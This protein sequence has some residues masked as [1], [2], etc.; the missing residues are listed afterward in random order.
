MAAAQT[1][2]TVEPA[3]APSVS[4]SGAAVSIWV[5]A[6]WLLPLSLLLAVMA[7][8][9][10]PIALVVPWV[11]SLDLHFAFTIDGLNRLFLFLITGVGAVIFFYTPAYLHGHPRLGM[12]MGLLCVFL[13]SMVGAV[14]AD[15]LLLLFL[16]WELTSVLSFLL[17]GFEH[18]KKVVRDSAQH[19]LL[20]TAGGGLALFGGFLL[21]LQAAPGLRLSDLPHL[22][23]VL[24]EDYRFNAGVV[25]VLIGAMTKS[26]QFP[27]HFWLPGAMAAPTPISAYLHSATMVKLGVYLM[28]RFDEAMGAVDWW[29]T[30]LTVIGTVTALWGAIHS[31]RERDMKAILAWSTVSALGTLTLLVGLPNELSALAFVAF[32]VAHASYKATLF[33]VV[34]NV[35]HVAGTR[36]IDRLR[37]MGRAM[38]MT[39]AAAIL[40]GLSMAGLP[41]SIGFIAKDTIK[42]S[43]ELAESAWPIVGAGV[44]VSAIGVAVAAVATVRIFLGPSNDSLCDSAH[45]EGVR[46]RLSPLVLAVLGIVLGLAPGLMQPILLDAAR[47]IAPTLQA[48][49][50]AVDNTWPTRLG[51]LAVVMMLG[52]IIYANWDRLHRCLEELKALER[53]GPASAYESA[54]GLLKGI[55]GATT[56]TLQSGRSSRYLIAT[57]VAI[58]VLL[59]P[60]LVQLAPRF[61]ELR[62]KGDIGLLLG[63]FTAI[64]GA[65]ISASGRDTLQ[66]LLGAG[67]V[68]YGSA[69]VFLFRG[70]PDLALTQLAVETV[71]VVLGAITLRRIAASQMKRHAHIVRVAAAVSF[72]VA[73]GAILLTL[74]LQPFDQA[75]SRYF[76]DASVPQAHGRNVVNVIIVDFR[77]LDTVGEITV[78]LLAT[79]AAWPLMRHIRRRIE[80]P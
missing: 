49:D 15:D 3:N 48:A 21:I 44:L 46:L 69:I 79:L 47:M 77:S 22:D 61:G 19:A 64:M 53:I 7:L 58:V 59:A 41:S 68:G 38:P 72:G 17:I 12:V 43:K 25:L 26:A 63:C 6:S 50:A 78:V 9:G 37:G 45:E 4:G 11:P 76:L 13:L 18:G 65:L 62:M 5:R 39:A 31:L 40:A 73:V 60:L 36:L 52:W 56:R 23:P 75:M 66:R 33:L 30:T 71:F 54:F 20:I 42:A 2:M 8:P 80:Q 28:A 35:D 70:A 51:S 34:G 29:E 32:V 74:M 1:S 57:T 24:L 10:E 27:F 55:A 67:A 16:F 14:L